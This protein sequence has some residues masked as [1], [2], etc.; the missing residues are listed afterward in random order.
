MI[1]RGSADEQ[2]G[3]IGPGKD[4]RPMRK[5]M[6]ALAAG[7]TGAALGGEVRAEECLLLDG[8]RGL[9]PNAIQP[10]GASFEGYPQVG[11]V[12]KVRIAGESIGASARSLVRAPLDSA[13]QL[14]GRTAERLIVRAR[15]VA[16]RPL[17]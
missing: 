6:R 15:E 12:Q 7:L 16:P 10:P 11:R 8:K 1:G 13:S 4:A 5:R 9:P 2:G 3:W 17:F 14:G